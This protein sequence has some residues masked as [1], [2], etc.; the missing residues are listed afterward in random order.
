MRNLTFV[1]QNL[2]IINVL[3]YFGTQLMGPEIDLVKLP[4]HP[5]EGFNI[6]DLNRYAFA[7]FYFESDYFRPFQIVTHMFMHG[8]IAH[9]FFN[10][11][12]LYMFG[13]PLEQL[14]GRKR[15]LIYYLMC[16]L[17]ALALTFLINFL[18]LHYGFLGTFNINKAMLGASGCIMGLLAG[19]GTK[20]PNAKLQLLF[21]P[22]PIKARTFVILYAALELYLGLGNFDT[23]VAHFAH[24]GGAVMGFILMSIWKDKRIA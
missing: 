12:A 5:P 3:M 19:F 8:T 1:V 18:Q 22:I 16:G 2:L 9:L 6:F 13:P 17:G 7:V 24:L 23:G 15:F 10:M 11:F 4:L 14:F 20:Y 21:P